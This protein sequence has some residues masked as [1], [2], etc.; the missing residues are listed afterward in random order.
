MS[1]IDLLVSE[2]SE[3][4]PLPPWS[5]P[6]RI[7]YRSGHCVDTLTVSWAESTLHLLSGRVAH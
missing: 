5:C 4:P 7:I 3:R 6:E 1:K 2:L